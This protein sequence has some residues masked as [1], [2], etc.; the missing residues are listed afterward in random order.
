MKPYNLGIC[1]KFYIT[2]KGKY[3]KLQVNIPISV[4]VQGFR[5]FN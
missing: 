1:D 3:E 2:V 5:N 4:L